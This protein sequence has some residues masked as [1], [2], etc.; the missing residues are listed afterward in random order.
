MIFVKVMDPVLSTLDVLNFFFQI[1]CRI[2][3][4]FPPF[5]SENKIEKRNEIT[6]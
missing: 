4:L 2:I 3:S 5:P 6:K 1:P